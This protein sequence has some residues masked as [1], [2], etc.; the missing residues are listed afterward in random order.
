MKKTLL[1]VLLGS[2]AFASFAQPIT[3]ESRAH[4]LPAEQLS[5]PRKLSIRTIRNR[6]L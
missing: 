5:K 3:I 2:F 1:A 4:S 6:M